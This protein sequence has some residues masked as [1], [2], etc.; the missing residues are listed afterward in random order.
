MNGKES[1]S[2]M[3]AMAV[4]TIM[5]LSC[6]AINGV[7]GTGHYALAV[8]SGPHES[9]VTTQDDACT[10]SSP[11]D[12]D[13]DAVTAALAPAEPQEY[14][15]SFVEDGLA[16]GTVWSVSLVWSTDNSTTNATTNST[17]D[18]ITF[19]EGNGNYTFSIWNVSGLDPTP[20]AGDIFVNGSSVTVN[21]TFAGCPSS[22]GFDWSPVI[23]IMCWAIIVAMVV[24]TLAIDRR[25]APPSPSSGTNGSPPHDAP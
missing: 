10:G 24:V 8:Q 6:F 7:T 14:N 3:I 19:Q 17:T 20:S 25:R 12:T 18:T 5:V 23:V 13:S 11:T 9:N 16:D 4:A 15:V 21:A 1:R 22:S 2:V